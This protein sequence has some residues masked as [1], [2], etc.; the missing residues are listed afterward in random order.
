MKAVLDA[1]GGLKDLRLSET[2][3]IAHLSRL[4]SYWNNEFPGFSCA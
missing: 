4:S 1:G 3:V 2:Q